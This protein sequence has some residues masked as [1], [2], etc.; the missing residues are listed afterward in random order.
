L[1]D[2]SSDDR[3]LNGHLPLVISLSG[4]YGLESIR[5]FPARDA[6]GTVAVCECLFR[7]EAA[8][9]AACSSAE[10]PDVMADGALFT[11][12]TP[13]RFRTVPLENN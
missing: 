6:D 13:H 8:V 2:A 1:I 12:L 10:T 5:V 3:R 7:D 11:D 4:K 9:E